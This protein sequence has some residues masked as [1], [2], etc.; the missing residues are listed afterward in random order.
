MAPFEITVGITTRDRPE[1]LLRCLHSL[2]YLQPWLRE[3]LIIED[4]PVRSISF[5]EWEKIIAEL[6]CP[7]RKEVGR[8]T[9]GMAK[10]R[11]EL[12]VAAGTP[13]VLLLDDDVELIDGE[14][15]I[16]LQQILTG[17]ARIG[18]VAFGSLLPNREPH[19]S[20]MQPSSREMLCFI[21][22]YTG[23]A[24]LLRRDLFLTLGGY[25]A[26]M[27]YLGEERDYC[28]RLRQMGGEV[29]YFPP[30]KVI[31]YSDA[32]H[33]SAER[34][35]YFTLRNR[36]RSSWRC[37]PWFWV[38]PQFMRSALAA[39]GMA[40]AGRV[41]WLQAWW[42]AAKS[43][44]KD[45]PQRHP[46]SWKMWR[47]QRQLS[48][49]P[50]LYVS[51]DGQG[52]YARKHAAVGGL[53]AWSHHQRFQTALKW[54]GHYGRG[55]LLDYGCGDGTL[56]RCLAEQGDYPFAR[57]GAEVDRQQIEDCSERLRFL[58]RTQFVSMEKLVS[59]GEFQ[60]V[61]CL[62]VL[63]HVVEVG[64]I[65]NQLEHSLQPGGF[66]IISVPV[67]TGWPLLLK[68]GVRR[69]AAWRGNRDYAMGERY[70]PREFW[71]AWTGGS[72]SRPIYTD[73][74]GFRY[75]GHKGFN[76]K[77]LRQQLTERFDLVQESASPVAWLPSQKW[78]ILRKHA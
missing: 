9:L 31:H 35:V 54:I 30:F 49:R 71:A 6:P 11:N 40:R 15:W 62:E 74:R 65:L 67:E 7:V 72:I 64:E 23:Y 73:K 10:R 5:S 42:A 58:P 25:D 28:L 52:H 57:V 19:P 14:G 63:E 39:L 43:L 70:T 37:D 18:A 76:W 24:H 8:Q 56:L 38:V 29:L 34:L 47:R 1:A 17:D 26:P 3:I 66:L 55:R 46:L 44:L 41:S 51:G 20:W 78:F 13:W 2:R 48:K 77:I 36:W 27:E 22:S 68:Q 16:E 61:L 32:G 59:E 33:R 53:L 50:E 21:A 4:G 69:L 45:R 75:H 12:V 60:I